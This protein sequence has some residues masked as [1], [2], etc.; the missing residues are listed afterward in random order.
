ML[1]VTSFMCSHRSSGRIQVLYNL[2]ISPKRPKYHH[3]GRNARFLIFSSITF[4]NLYGIVSQL[5][6]A[7]ETKPAFDQLEMFAYGTFDQYQGMKNR[8]NLI[9]LSTASGANELAIS[10]SNN[11]KSMAYY[12]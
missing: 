5:A 8:A 4:P 2:N 6:D 7:P 10:W 12:R 3:K 9:S 11:E 1:F